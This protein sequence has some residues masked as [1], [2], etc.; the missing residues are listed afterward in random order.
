MKGLKKLEKLE[1]RRI[2]KLT[3]NGKIRTKRNSAS[4]PWKASH[5]AIVKH[6]QYSHEEEPMY[7]RSRTVARESKSDDRPD[8]HAGAPP[9]EVLKAIISIAANHKE[10]F[11]VMHIDVS[12]AYFHANVQR[13]DV[14]TIAS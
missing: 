6:T 8:L 10:T 2:L 9:S 12:R 3:R 11:S 5:D 1:H 13:P 14:G 7:N 4:Q